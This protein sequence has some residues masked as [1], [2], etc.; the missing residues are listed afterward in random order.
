MAEL[1]TTIATN[2]SSCCAPEAQASCCESSAK[3]ECC[4]SSHGADCQCWAGK[5]GQPTVDVQTL[6]VT[7]KQPSGQ[8]WMEAD[9]APLLVVQ[10]G[11]ASVD[12][13]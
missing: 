3:A 7:P 8:A 4:G 2:A 5:R 13:S 12:A 1:T 10:P 6:A 11:R 9:H